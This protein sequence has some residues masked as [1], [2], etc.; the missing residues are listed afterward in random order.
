MKNND[1]SLPMSF[2]AR[3]L[4]VDLLDDEDGVLDGLDLR[5]SAVQRSDLFSKSWGYPE[6]INFLGDCL[7]LSIL[8]HSNH[9]FW[10]TL[11]NTEI[12]N[13]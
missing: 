10:G 1:N 11:I 8:D 13:C 3:H 5:P 4:L 7:R 2:Q 6:I 9:P 12:P